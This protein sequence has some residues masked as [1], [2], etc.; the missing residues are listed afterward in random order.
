MLRVFAGEYGEIWV[1][2]IW[3]GLPSVW[4]AWW[5]FLAWLAG[6]LDWM[7]GWLAGL[8]VVEETFRNG[9]LET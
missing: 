6:C 7:A 9:Q 3:A 1:G 5:V 2:P 8:A 4:L